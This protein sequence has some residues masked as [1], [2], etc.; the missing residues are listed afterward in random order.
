MQITKI[1]FKPAKNKFAV[2]AA[3]DEIVIFQEL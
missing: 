2:L 3:H 1:P